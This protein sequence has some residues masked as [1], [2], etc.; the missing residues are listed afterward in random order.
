MPAAKYR[1]FALA[2]NSHGQQHLDNGNFYV[3]D[4][5][6]YCNS[7]S[8]NNSAA[9]CD[10]V[11]YSNE[12]H[13]A[14]M[15]SSNKSRRDVSHNYVNV[16]TFAANLSAPLGR[17][18]QFKEDVELYHPVANQLREN[19][20]NGSGNFYLALDVQ[21]GW[22]DS[23]PA[24]N[25]VTKTDCYNGM[26]T[27]ENYP[28]CTTF[29][30]AQTSQNYCNTRVG[31]PQSHLS[32]CDVN[33]AKDADPYPYMCQ[34]DERSKSEHPRSSV[35][36]LSELEYAIEHCKEVEARALDTKSSES[37]SVSHTQ[38]ETPN[39]MNSSGFYPL[40]PF[41]PVHEMP[42]APPLHQHVKKEHEYTQLSAGPQSGTD[43]V[44]PAKRKQH[45][46][47][48]TATK[49]SVVAAIN[50]QI[51]ILREE[52][53]ELRATTMTFKQ[54]MEK[55]F[56]DLAAL[57]GI[58]H[59]EEDSVFRQVPVCADDDN[60]TDYVSPSQ[61]I[62]RELEMPLR[63]T[64]FPDLR[65]SES[66]V[67]A[68]EREQMEISSLSPTPTNQAQTDI[69]VRQSNSIPIDNCKAFP[70]RDH[71]DDKIALER[72]VDKSEKSSPKKAKSNERPNSDSFASALNSEKNFSPRDNQLSTMSL[73][74]TPSI[75]VSAKQQHESHAYRL[76]SRHTNKVGG[77]NLRILP[78]LSHSNAALHV[79]ECSIDSGYQGS[80]I[81]T[82]RERG[83]DLTSQVVTPASPINESPVESS[84]DCEKL[85]ATARAAS[86]EAQETVD[87]VCPKARTGKE[88]CCAEVFLQGAVGQDSTFLT[89]KHLESFV[90]P[91]KQKLKSR[92]TLS[93]LDS[94]EAG[95]ETPEIAETVRPKPRASNSSKLSTSSETNE[96]VSKAAR[97]VP[98]PRS[99]LSKD[100]SKGHG[101]IVGSEQNQ[102]CKDSRRVYTES[103]VVSKAQVQITDC[104]TIAEADA[105]RISTSLTQVY[106][107][108]CDKRSAQATDE[109][110][111]SKSSQPQCLTVIKQNC[112]APAG[113][114]VATAVQKRVKLGIS[115]ISSQ[116]R[117]QAKIVG[118]DVK[119][120]KVNNT[121]Q[122]LKE[123]FAAVLEHSNA[124]LKSGQ[125]VE[126]DS[127]LSVVRRRSMRMMTEFQIYDFKD[128]S[129]SLTNL[130]N[131]TPEE[132]KVAD[133]DCISSSTSNLLT[134][135][136]PTSTG[137]S[138][139]V[140][141][142]PK[143]VANKPSFEPS[144]VEAPNQTPLNQQED[145]NQSAAAE[146][147]LSTS[148]QVKR[149]A[150]VIYT[151]CHGSLPLPPPPPPP[152]HSPP[153]VASKPPSV[154][155][156][157]A[158][159]YSELELLAQ[160]S[161]RPTALFQNNLIRPKP[162]LLGMSCDRGS[163]QSNGVAGVKISPSAGSAFTP[164]LSSSLRS[165][166][167]K[168]SP[169]TDRYD[170]PFCPEPEVK[171]RISLPMAAVSNRGK[172]LAEIL[173]PNNQ[174]ADSENY[175]N[176]GLQRRTSLRSQR[177]PDHLESVISAE[178]AH[179]T[180]YSLYNQQPIENAPNQSY[181]QAKPNKHASNSYDRVEDRRRPASSD[182]T[183]SSS[184]NRSNKHDL[185][186]Q[187][188]RYNR[189]DNIKHVISALRTGGYLAH[190]DAGNTKS[191]SQVSGSASSSMSSN[192]GNRSRSE[193]VAA[194]Q[195]QPQ[196]Q[197]PFVRS[198]KQRSS[199]GPSRSNKKTESHDYE[200]VRSADAVTRSRTN[201][202][203]ASE[204]DRSVSRDKALSA[205][206]VAPELPSPS[207]GHKSTVAFLRASFMVKRE[208]PTR[209]ATAEG[210]RDMVITKPATDRSRSTSAGGKSKKHETILNGK[211]S[212]SKSNPEPKPKESSAS[213][214][215]VKTDSK[216][217]KESK[218]T[219]KGNKNDAKT[220][221]SQKGGKD[222]KHGSSPALPSGDP[223]RHGNADSEVMER[224]LA[225][226]AASHVT[227]TRS[228]LQKL[229]SSFRAPRNKTKFLQAA[230][231][232][233]VKD[234]M[235]VNRI[236]D[237][238]ISLSKKVPLRKDHYTYV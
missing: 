199:S 43:I 58:G 49:A 179:V 139:S 79:S 97:P 214:K 161:K 226:A 59:P 108:D 136:S 205:Q 143:Q 27:Y 93:S 54:Q 163:G 206:D 147:L 106:A 129:T 173:A 170:V 70:L 180:S 88:N 102:L 233:R 20:N 209:S 74:H 128:S 72:L 188:V 135:Q 56:R 164:V 126:D 32:P 87:Q 189:S 66:P 90:R 40:K 200:T 31:M 39:E 146:P 236:A 231:A 153:L 37:F 86:E 203:A 207:R 142:I 53:L 176:T 115:A 85:S 16:G 217:P 195:Q 17:P 57:S 98:K 187:P 34:S 29:S 219:K 22:R 190:E 238:K 222:T 78:V 192:K 18:A 111:S 73:P 216:P 123:K 204:R 132:R 65:S 134:V 51:Q 178:Q 44:D 181:Q 215:K 218:W 105:M 25:N 154:A 55:M 193:R 118:E 119:L 103:L 69:E 21:S 76:V 24:Y 60:R 162:A 109:Q 19:V 13:Q 169:I 7:Y 171:R 185:E 232:N 8:L 149:G 82:P 41:A 64:V 211:S 38:A 120:R 112:G 227:T 230:Q 62:I 156:S 210:K 213:S 81:T 122:A 184:A 198:S 148:P 229:R 95:K 80:S 84:I 30:A 133:R 67:S 3:K 5:Y 83:R 11:T 168:P 61:C 101:V 127:E 221:A 186:N 237:D 47:K 9:G 157:E 137:L 50:G 52:M 10:S 48:K 68:N 116:H 177:K 225:A 114:G 1:E 131:D 89:S 92:D 46:K 152:P 100:S 182:R 144:K 224:F 45:S 138:T 160:S 202:A 107:V 150:H 117:E 140:S 191:S 159:L 196:Q 194:S 220:A 2:A 165:L 145:K 166:Q 33:I 113:P 234:D 201:L 104:Q 110:K 125:R 141:S 183:R 172:V 151:S 75:G 158:S 12:H 223:I 197:Q 94:L 121:K 96:E 167:D 42:P 175:Q 77:E 63:E 99:A 35:T 212:K 174:S 15:F 91:V 124:K 130:L 28:L 208:K 235:D 71:S 14:P 23:P 6:R 4:G 155:G 228:P 26:D 36:N